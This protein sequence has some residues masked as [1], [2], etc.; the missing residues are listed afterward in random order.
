MTDQGSQP[1]PEAPAQ[2]AAKDDAYAAAE[3]AAKSR[4]HAITCVSVRELMA[5]GRLVLAQSRLLEEIAAQA[6]QRLRAG[7]ESWGEVVALMIAHG[8]YDGEYWSRL[9]EELGQLHQTNITQT[10]TTE[11]AS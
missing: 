4:W 6:E 9:K 5:M 8:F 10:S 1:H 11:H 7:D 3:R 2:S